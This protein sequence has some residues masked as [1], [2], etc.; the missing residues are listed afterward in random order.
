MKLS[1]FVIKNGVLEKY[2]GNEKEVT[3]PDGVKWIGWSA[4]RN[5][6]QIEKVVLPFGVT[7]IGESIRGMRSPFFHKYSRKP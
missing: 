7:R 2:T 5:C 1:D 6:V 4:F 3:V